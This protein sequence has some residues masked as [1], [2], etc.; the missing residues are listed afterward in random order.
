M[1]FMNI[2]SYEVHRG[3]DPLHDDPRARGQGRRGP[4]REGPGEGHGVRREPHRARGVLEP[5]G[6]GANST[7]TQVSKQL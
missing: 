3:H 2:D 4:R 7:L 5:R 1:V 6:S